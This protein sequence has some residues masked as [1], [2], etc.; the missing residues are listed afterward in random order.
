MTYKFNSIGINEGS[1][2]VK[3]AFSKTFR[4]RFYSNSKGKYFLL[5]SKVGATWH[6]CKIINDNY[7]ENVFKK[8]LN[9]NVFSIIYVKIF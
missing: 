5:K 1:K 8:P 7:L 3:H 6:I 2:D 4:D 9:S